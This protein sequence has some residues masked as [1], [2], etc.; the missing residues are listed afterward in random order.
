[1]WKTGQLISDLKSHLSLPWLM[2][3]DLNKIF[4]HGEKKRGPSKPQSTIDSFLEA[5]LDCGLF[6]M[7]Y[8]GYHYTWCNF[9]D[10][11]VVVEE[12]L[13]RFCA[14]IDWSILF[15]AASVSYMDFNMSDHL[16]ILL[17]FTLHAATRGERARR[18]HFKNM[19]FTEP[20][21]KEVVMSAWTSASTPDIVKNLLALMDRC[22]AELSKWN[23]ETFGHVGIEIQKLEAQL[24]NQHNAPSCTRI[25]GQIREWHKKEEIL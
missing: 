15:P 9:Q 12:R 24:H 18:F 8:S 19:L 16:P 23:H 7:D 11:G 5:F 17:K 20:S 1:M 6:D 25:L 22:S 4:Y 10:N 13:D 3:G 21:C 2:G 14:N